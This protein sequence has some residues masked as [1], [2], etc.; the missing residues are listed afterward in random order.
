MGVRRGIRKRRLIPAHAG[1]T[2]S[3][4]NTRRPLAA[5]PRSRGEN[6]DLAA[7]PRTSHGSSPLT[8]GKPD[9]RAS[10]RMLHRLIPAHAGKTANHLEFPSP[11]AAHP[12]SRGENGIEITIDQE[13]AG[14]S[15]LTRGKRCSGL[16]LSGADRLIPAHA[17]KTVAAWLAY[18]ACAAHPR[19]RGENADLER[20]DQ[21]RSGSSPLTRGKPRWPQRRPRTRRLIP[22]HAGKTVG[23]FPQ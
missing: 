22:A 9:R 1:K 4:P 2:S 13:K 12:R 14:S 8:R 6:R 16:H 15:P 10:A 20:D 11:M 23:S 19:S 5:H 7:Q 3:P 21:L 17:G 18:A